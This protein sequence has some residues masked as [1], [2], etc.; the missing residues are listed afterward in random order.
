MRIERQIE[1]APGRTFRAA[2]LLIGV[3]IV[4]QIGKLYTY[5]E[6]GLKLLIREQEAINA[7]AFVIHD[8][9]EEAF[10]EVRD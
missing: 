6:S 8:P 2:S 1:I 9:R 4:G 7:L 10:R 3:A 5:D